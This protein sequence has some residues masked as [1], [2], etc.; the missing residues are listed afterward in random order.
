MREIKAILRQDRLLGV[1]RALR[2]IEGMP[3]ITVSVVHGFGR[4]HVANPDQAEPTM[5]TELAKLETV[6]PSE[7]VEA[8]VE[9]IR[10][11]A[12]TGRSGDGKIFVIPVESMTR[13]TTTA[14]DGGLAV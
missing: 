11:T 10:R 9:T 13:I 8:V 5:E 3:G 12:S 2:Q 1:V 7:L 6:V 14:D 4:S